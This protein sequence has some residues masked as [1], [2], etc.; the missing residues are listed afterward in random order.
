M[1]T[2]KN[3]YRDLQILELPI[4]E[5]FKQQLFA[6]VPIGWYIIITDVKNSTAAVNAGKHNDVNLVAASSII[7]AINVAKKNDVDIPFFFTGDG[8]TIMVP[9]YLLKDVMVGLNVHNINSMKNFDLQM[10]LGCISVQD[11]KDAGHFLQIAKVQFGKNLSKP[12]VIGDGLKYAE[13]MI[14]Y[15]AKDQDENI[16]DPNILNLEG[17]EC[18]WDKVKPPLEENEVVCYLIEASDP[19]KQ[20]EVYGSVLRKIEEIFGPLEERNPL[21]V[22]RLKL[23]V[24]FQKIRGEILAKFGRWKAADFIATFLKTFIGRFFIRYNLKINN[25]PGQEYLR[26]VIS[27]A[28]IL[29]IDGRINTIISGKKEKRLQFI[30]Y[31]SEQEKIGKLVYGHFISKESVITCYIENRDSKHIHF[32]DG[33][34]GGYTEASKELKMKF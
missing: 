9:E 2:S 8:A 26:Q 22:D 4:P 24:T 1:N 29:T 13:K 11:I 6:D 12:V 31:L 18:R 17:L 3:F 32:V 33:S 20:M 28:D 30:Q 34:D 19:Q 7:A 5:V 23:L 15:A 21:S 27:N 25:I 10:H 16:D 14:K